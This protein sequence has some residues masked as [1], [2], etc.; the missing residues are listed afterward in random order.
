MDDIRASEDRPQGAKSVD[1]VASG[2]EWNCPVCD[3]L[4]KIGWW[5]ET[6]TCKNPK[7]GRSFELNPPEHA[8]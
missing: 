7:C 8:Y 3:T 2:Y 6:V 4:N 1:C 5:K